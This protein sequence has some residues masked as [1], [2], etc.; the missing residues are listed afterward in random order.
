MNLAGLLSGGEQ[1]Q[2]PE[3]LLMQLQQQN[4]PLSSL[5]PGEALLG[6]S[7]PQLGM[8]QLPIPGMG[9]IPG[10]PGMGAPAGGGMPQQMP[11]LPGIGGMPE[12]AQGGLPR[13]PEQM[14]GFGLGS[15]AP[16]VFGP[17][18]REE[19]IREKLIARLLGG[20]A[21]GY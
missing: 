10:L 14:S 19:G 13:F 21:G 16:K 6:Q 3:Q 7:N 11:G 1:A 15:F 4:N 20:G 12:F 17:Q 18:N 9:G 8:P 2:A 5:F